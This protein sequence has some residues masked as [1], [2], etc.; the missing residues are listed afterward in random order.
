MKLA[1][2]TYSLS[3]W[4]REQNQPLE[5]SIRRIADLGAQ[6][7]EFLAFAGPNDSHADTLKQATKLR[8]LAES[9]KLGVA[10]YCVGANLLVPPERQAK[11]VQRLKHEVDI[12]AELGVRSMRH[13]ICPGFRDF[14]DFK[15]AQTFA[16]ALKVVVP[17]I[18]EVADH[19]QQRG[20]KT[21]LENHGFFMQA[22]QRV[23]KL[24]NT[25]DHP[26]FGLTIDMGNF[27][28]VNADP[29]AAVRQLAK[30]VVMAHA[31]DFHVKHKGPDVPKVGWFETPTAIA[32]RG[33]VVGHGAIDVPAQLKLL[34]R[35]RYDGFLSLEF[36]G[37]ENPIQAVEWGLN[38][39]RD[40]LKAIDAL[41]A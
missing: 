14:P 10:G 4:C 1:V 13:D 24:L 5:E 32:L 6:G 30:Y 35:A 7:V 21:T 11:V 27:L 37:M 16:A 22:P 26:N 20:L 41:T 34:K 18:R 33:A 28:C 25:V 19:G 23:E 29:V 36:E 39:L 8:K 38:Y 31:K 2:S 17:A 40:H 9:L 3:R 15:G 12:A